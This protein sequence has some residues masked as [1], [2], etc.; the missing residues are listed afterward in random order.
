MQPTSTVRTCFCDCNSGI[1]TFCQTRPKAGYCCVNCRTGKII[2]W[3]YTVDDTFIGADG[4]TYAVAQ[5]NLMVG[6]LGAEGGDGSSLTVN[7]PTVGRILAVPV[8]SG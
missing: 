2:A 8:L 5:G 1:T 3:G 7:I 4:E 6:G